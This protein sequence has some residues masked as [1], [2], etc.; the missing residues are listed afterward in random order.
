MMSKEQYIEAITKSAEMCD[1]T[2]LL[3]LIFRLLQKYI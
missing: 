1:D 2:E 3:D